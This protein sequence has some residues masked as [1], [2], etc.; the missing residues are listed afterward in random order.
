[1]EFIDVIKSRRSV[2]RF[3]DRDVEEVK[4]EQILECGRLAPSWANKQCW[5][6]IVV[7]DRKKLKHCLKQLV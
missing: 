2:R 1:M 5:S 3:S 4:I 7:R 6:F